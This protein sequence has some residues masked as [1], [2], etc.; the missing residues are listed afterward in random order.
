MSHDNDK[1]T[2]TMPQQ[3]THQIQH[4][5]NYPVF[6]LSLL[7]AAMLSANAPTLFADELEPI[8]VQDG[9][10]IDS[11]NIDTVI[12]SEQNMRIPVDAAEALLEV[13]GVSASR[14]S[15][16]GLDPIVRG[17]S[18]TQLN[19]LLDGGYVHGGCPNR[20]DP[21]TSFAVLQSYDR[22]VVQ[23]GVQSVLYGL[24]GSGGTILFERD[25]AAKAAKEGIQGSAGL[26]GSTNGAGG[27]GYV[28]GLFSNG[29]AYMRAYGEYQDTNSYKDGDGRVVPSATTKTSGGA[30]LGLRLN[31]HA[32]IEAGVDLTRASDTLYAGADM[33]SPY[34]NMNAYR[35]KFWDQKIDGPVSGVKFEAWRSDVDHLMDNYS[36]RTPPA[37]LAMYRAAPSEVTTQGM[38]LT[39]TSTPM[40]ALKLNYGMDYQDVN[41]K[42][43]I[44]N[45]A[46]IA[47]NAVLG[48]LWPE[49]EFSSVGGFV[50]GEYS[51][52]TA[53][54]IK[55]GL[56][57]D[58]VNSSVNGSL[59][60]S[61]ATN[62]MVPVAIR[63]AAQSEQ[64]NTAFGGLLRYEQ[65][66]NK[67]LTLFAGISRSVRQPDATERYVL[68][69]APTGITWIGNPSLDPE[70]HHQLDM[71][72]SGKANSSTVQWDAVLYYD[73]VSN[74]VLRDING[75]TPGG[76]IAGVS[77]KSTIY[78]NVDATLWGAELSAQWM[79]AKGWQTY[80]SL[81]YVNAEN[82]TDNRNIAQIPPLNGRIGVDYTESVWGVGGR[83]RFAAQQ[84]NIDTL[85]GLD[86]IATPS[87]G[88]VD[89]YGSY[90][91]AKHT[92]LKAG[93]DNLF[94]TLYAE[95]V[96]RAYSGLFG[97][98]SD[99]VYEPGISFWARIDTTF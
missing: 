89:L 88:V 64:D 73:N 3:R 77:P 67:N 75:S 1:R 93:V 84:N 34:D 5:N 83:V 25:T 98:P 86:T 80:G 16:H 12:P 26:S 11:P 20:M 71:G 37:S 54:R 52:S 42:G 56:R 61:I 6:R 35:F 32:G 38:R 49:A 21:P 50:E 51:L 63:N 30:T 58:G 66:I 36:L 19:V 94:D 46:S 85:S 15:Q 91:V 62:P 81:A 95:H 13:P 92:V 45:P 27:T 74:Y 60:G 29:S 55:A 31:E 17:Q 24:G 9:V 53:Q 78:R 28:D 79:F 7:A 39:L 68:K 10:I 43:W 18:A 59:M 65:D 72:L 96:N 23:K 44:N 90:T 41:R 48:W 76:A 87:Y 70:T 82:T 4:A 99:R 8:E 47:P 97:N 40:N 22:V 33:D 14:M 2:E 69:A 57:V